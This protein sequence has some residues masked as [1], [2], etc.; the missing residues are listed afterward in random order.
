VWIAVLL[1]YQRQREQPH[2]KI[3]S[4]P[5]FQSRL[6]LTQVASLASRHVQ[7]IVH[8]AFFCHFPAVI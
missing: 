8:A 2:V 7:N 6:K 1:F 3:F 4:I 5:G